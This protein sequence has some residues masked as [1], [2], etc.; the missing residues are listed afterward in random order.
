MSATVEGM[1][2]SRTTDQVKPTQRN[3]TTRTLK[4]TLYYYYYS[5]C[6]CSKLE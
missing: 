1:S 3:P 6:K 5:I 2:A 4:R